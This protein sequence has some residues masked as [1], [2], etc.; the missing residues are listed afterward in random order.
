ME[1]HPQTKA[2]Q[3]AYNSFRALGVSFLLWPLTW[4]LMIVIFQIF[5]FDDPFNIMLFLGFIVGFK[6]FGIS[7]IVPGIMA[8]KSLL[9]GTSRKGLSVFTATISA[10]GFIGVVEFIL[11]SPELYAPLFFFG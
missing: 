1:E 3:L 4:I 2:N 11:N 10:I 5:Y 7:L 8:A 9:D 6:V